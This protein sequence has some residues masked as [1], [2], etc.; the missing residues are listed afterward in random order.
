MKLKI[1]III[2][3]VFMAASAQA[4]AVLANK[5]SG[6][7]LLQ[8]QSA[9]QAWYVNPAD[10][11][12]YYLGRPADA[13]EI[14]R[15]LG[16]GISE[17]DFDKLSS[18]KNMADRV[19][20]KIILQVQSAGQAWYVNP[21][22]G[23]RYYLGRP[24][25]AFEIMKQLALGI[26]N[27]NLTQIPIGQLAS[28]KI[29]NPVA[30]SPQPSLPSP[31]QESIL[32]QVADGIR[33]NNLSEIE[34]FF[35]PEMKKAII[36]TMAALNSESKLLLANILSSAKLDSQTDGQKIYS[37]QAYFSLG[38]YDVPLYFYVNKQPDGNWLIANL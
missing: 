30:S 14:M 25:D 24:A 15:H 4:E 26:T 8:V 38:G 5:L 10:G 2:I 32:A 28:E 16:L 23:Q 7:I 9:G 37:A 22:D 12:R 13:F 3:F 17:A 21:A 33:N 18:D 19:K 11:Q 31:S 29:T 1:L 20:G 35:T 34:S 6:R 36:Y 27:A